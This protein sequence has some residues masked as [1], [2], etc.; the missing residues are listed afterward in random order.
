M[1][2]RKCANCSHFSSSRRR[3]PKLQC[4]C[5][6]FEVACDGYQI[7][8]R[9]RHSSAKHV[10]RTHGA[11]NNKMFKRLGHI[12]DQLMRI[13]QAKS[14]IQHKEP[15]IR[16]FF[17]LQYTKFRMLKLY[18]T[19]LQNFALVTSLRRWKWTLIHCA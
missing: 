19:F 18:Y 15:I 4:C 3:E 7:R 16:G 5:T 1:F 12:N 11:I 13:E 8:D 6:D 2:L 14:E 10:E 9:S 17:I